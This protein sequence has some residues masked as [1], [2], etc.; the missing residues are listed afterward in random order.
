MT[1][2]IQIKIKTGNHTPDH[3]QLFQI[4]FRSSDK[5]NVLFS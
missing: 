3:G 4:D 5:V 2:A 1:K